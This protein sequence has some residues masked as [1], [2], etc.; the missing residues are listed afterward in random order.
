[1]AGRGPSLRRRHRQFDPNDR[2]QTRPTRRLAEPN[3]PA[4]IVVIGERQR[5]DAQFNRLP[6]QNFRCRGPI[7]QRE[8]GVAVKLGVRGHGVPEQNP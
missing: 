1:M 4:Q 2:L 3:D 8:S 5:L 7:K 6:H